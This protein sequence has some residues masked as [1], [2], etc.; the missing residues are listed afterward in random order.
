[1]FHN[2]ASLV[3]QFYGSGNDM[4]MEFVQIYQGSIF[5]AGYCELLASAVFVTD[6]Y[7]KPGID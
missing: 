4:G 1:M 5:V 7:P 6:P 3:C 2:Y